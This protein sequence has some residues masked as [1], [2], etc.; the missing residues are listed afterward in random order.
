MTE[1]VVTMD[2]AIAETFAQS[3]IVDGISAPSCLAA[4]ALKRTIVVTPAIKP[5]TAILN[6]PAQPPRTQIQRQSWPSTSRRLLVCVTDRSHRRVHCTR[7]SLISPGTHYTNA[8]RPPAL[9]GVPWL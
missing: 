1:R 2:C 7:T 8:E 4:L 5:S 6:S 9:G 3:P